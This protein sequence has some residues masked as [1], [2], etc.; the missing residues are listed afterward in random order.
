M[1]LA[2]STRTS[3]V[4]TPPDP[5]AGVVICAPPHD[6]SIAGLRAAMRS[7]GLIFSMTLDCGLQW[8]DQVGLAT[9]ES[10]VARGGMVAWEFDRLGDAIA[11]HK[12]LRAIVEGT[13]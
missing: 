4:L 7:R 13:A 8:P 12:R 11:A 10:I 9:T 5:G 2:S 3:I 6:P 1:M